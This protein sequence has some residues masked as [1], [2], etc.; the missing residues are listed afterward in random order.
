[1]NSSRKGRISLPDHEALSAEQRAIYETV[2]NGPRGKIV[3][4]LRAVIHSPE[5]ADPWQK[6]GAYVRYKTLI[7]EALKELAIIICARRWN[8]EVEW[9][10]HSRIAREAGV[11]D[12]VITAILA[13]E[14]PQFDDPAAAEIYDYVCELQTHGAVSDAAYRPVLERWGERGIVELTAIAGYYSMVAMMLNAHRIPLPP[15]ETR[16]LIADEGSELAALAPR[17][18]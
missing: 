1:M 4:P 10:I 15:G 11:P 7:P 17:K 5:L 8:S 13:G 16:S 12:A 18:V 3:G 9:A 2:V 14:A 6:L